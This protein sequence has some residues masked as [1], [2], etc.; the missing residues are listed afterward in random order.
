VALEV[1]RRRFGGERKEGLLGW[2]FVSPAFI[3]LLVFALLPMAYALYLSFFKI[4]LVRDQRQF[5]GAFNYRYIF[6]DETFWNAM[7]NSARYALMSVPI[8]M[9]VGLGVALLVNQKLRGVTIFRTLYYIPSI[10]SGIALSMLW[11]YVYLPNTG[12]INTVLNW[13]GIDSTTDFINNISWAMWAL[14]VMAALNGVGPKMILFLAG[15][16]N[17]PQ[18]LYE[19]SQ[20]DGATRTRTFWKITVPMLAPTTFF[21]MVTSTI[22]AMQVF[23]PVYLMTKGGPEDSTDVV[24]YHIY[25][26]AWV[27]FNTGLAAAQSFVLLAAIVVI[28]VFQFRLQRNQLRG[29]TTA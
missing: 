18:E 28:S 26:E 9:A 7:W 16:M 25:R 21:V 1:P 17:I 23:T 20:L 27:Q 10:A 19:A 11:L 4:H 22:G 29:Y 24:G 12:M 13:L 8:G 5:V 6:G 2:L 15:L 14:V 3:H